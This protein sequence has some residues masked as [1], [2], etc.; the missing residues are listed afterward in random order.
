MWTLKTV[1][2]LLKERGQLEEVGGPVF[3]VSL[4]E[5]VGFATNVDYYARIVVEK[6]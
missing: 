1:T 4:S 3:L 2:F 6:S 5:Q